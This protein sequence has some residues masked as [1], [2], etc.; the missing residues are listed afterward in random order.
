MRRLAHDNLKRDTRLGYSDIP[1]TC[2]LYL[3]PARALPVWLGEM[4][5]ESVCVCQEERVWVP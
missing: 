5:R 2:A 4:L 3:Y 1:L